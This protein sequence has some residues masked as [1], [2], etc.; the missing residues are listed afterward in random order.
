MNPKKIAEPTK[1]FSLGDKRDSRLCADCV[2]WRV[3][4]TKFAYVLIRPCRRGALVAWTGPDA[5]SSWKLTLRRAASSRRDDLE[6]PSN[7]DSTRPAPL[8]PTT[9]LGSLLID[10][11]SFSP[12]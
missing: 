2:Q 4:A 11:T 10:L 7:N 3:F 1:G 8:T 5:G 12:P 6:S 9:Q